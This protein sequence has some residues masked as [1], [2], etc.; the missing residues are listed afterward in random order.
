MLSLVR[1]SINGLHEAPIRLPVRP[2]RNASYTGA[3]R[4]GHRIVPRHLGT[5]AVP[6]GSPGAGPF[7][8]GLPRRALLEVKVGGLGPNRAARP[9][10][11]IVSPGCRGRVDEEN[12]IEMAGRDNRP[13]VLPRQGV[14]EG[15]A[16]ASGLVA[17]REPFRDGSFVR[18]PAEIDGR[19]LEPCERER[20]VETPLGG[21]TDLEG[22]EAPAWPAAV[23]RLKPS[24]V[25][26]EAEHNHF[27]AQRGAKV[28]T[29]TVRGRPRF[30]RGDM[31]VVRPH[32]HLRIRTLLI[33]DPPYVLGHG[34]IAHRAPI[35]PNHSH[36]LAQ[37]PRVLAGRA[38]RT[39]ARTALVPR[40]GLVEGVLALANG[41]IDRCPLRR[42]R[43]AQALRY[44]R[45]R[46]G[47]QGFVHPRGLC[48]IDLAKIL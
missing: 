17:A 30:G 15:R 28:G 29:H 40:S 32:H 22:A 24:A 48:G 7:R 12:R 26:R 19:G 33:E 23:D 36:P 10:P 20:L 31:S 9:L 45:I 43:T 41:R 2:P 6:G 21:G 25:E 35:G 34:A 37:D 44:E 11:P 46:D 4:A 47:R 18:N 38:P 27:S 39:R 3:S 16:D 1:G 8:R 13:V 14:R 5:V 42:R